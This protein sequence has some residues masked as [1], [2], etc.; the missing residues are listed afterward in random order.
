MKKV[1]IS[2]L[3]A[4]LVGSFI[5]LPVFACLWDH[6]TLQ[7]EQAR[8]PSA[9][10]LITGKF[11]R[12]STQFYEWR[13]KNR[14]KKLAQDPEQFSYYDDLAV[15]YQKTGQFE[16][17]VQ[18]ML[19]KDKKK[20]GLYETNANLGTFYVLSGKLGDGLKY[21]NKA[22]EINP[23]AHFDRERY[24]KW[25]VEYALSRQQE[26]KLHF[27]LRAPQS[28][29]PDAW[30][31]VY[32]GKKTFA[33]FLANRLKIQ[34]RLPVIESQKAVKAVLG[35]MRFAD[36]DNPLLLEVLGDLLRYTEHSDDA[37]Q[38]ATRAYLAASYKFKG[39]PEEKEYRQFAERSLQ[40]QTTARYS[41]DQLDLSQ[42]EISFAKERADAENWYANLRKHEQK[43]I[44]DDLDVDAEFDKLYKMP[45]SVNGNPLA[46]FDELP[47]PPWLGAIFGALIG[48]SVVMQ[49]R[50]RRKH[51]ASQTAEPG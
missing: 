5:P 37:K 48:V 10:E 45:P 15:A 16:K 40:M 27:P 50:S 49:R 51:R 26:G 23:Q 13:I 1:R 6:D 11:L 41:N 42:M 46:L 8:F 4:A 32:N 31:D 18:T 14:L 25:L 21:I 29:T 28:N 36:Y 38:L 2:I 39:Y 17:A 24:Q 34:G 35:M 33:G 43:W 3:L 19:V 47:F 44:E 9:T 22:L 30:M 20:P 12:H 7:Q